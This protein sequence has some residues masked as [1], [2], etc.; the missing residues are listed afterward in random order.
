MKGKLLAKI[1]IQSKVFSV[2]VWDD[3]VAMNA[4]EV[5]EAKKYMAFP[6]RYKFDP[7]DPYGSD[8]FII[9]ASREIHI[10][11]GDLYSDEIMLR[12]LAHEIAHAIFH[13]KDKDDYY[14]DERLVDACAETYE[15]IY[16]CIE[17]V[18]GAIESR[19]THA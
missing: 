12:N 7:E 18:K 15:E 8:G 19:K 2:Y 10:V 11:K 1:I 14:K 16:K 17:D 6:D 5:E 13:C 4:Y 3:I 9:P